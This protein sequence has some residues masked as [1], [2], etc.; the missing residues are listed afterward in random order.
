VIISND[1]GFGISTRFNLS[2]SISWAL[3]SSGNERL[4]KTVYAKFVLADGSRSSTY[5]D[6]IILDET[7]PV[8]DDLT[9]S[10]YDGEG[11]S[12]AALRKMLTVKASDSNSGIAKF[13]IRSSVSSPSSYANATTPEAVSHSVAVVTEATSVEVRVIDQAGNL[14]GWKK[15]SFIQMSSS[16]VASPKA[17]PTVVAATAVLKGATA[18]VSVSV[19]SSLAKTC[20]TKLV[21]GKKVS[22]CKAAAIVVSVSGGVTKTYSAKSGSNA[23]KMPA[24]KGATVTIKVGGKVIKKIKL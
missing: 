12:V 17:S 21:K 19:P 4:P 2:E 9:S 11:V 20:T 16:P 7:A 6:D 13:E 10:A 23:F 8:F 1:G 22:T 5:T 3:Q 15:V 14:S 18:N 24:K